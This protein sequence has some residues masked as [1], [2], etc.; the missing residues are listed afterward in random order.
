M[1]SQG[2]VRRAVAAAIGALALWAATAAGA[3]A[4]S[5]IEISM[6]SDV[7][8]FTPVEVTV[9]GVAEEAAELIVAHRSSCEWYGVPG[10]LEG[11]QL[12]PGPFT[13]SQTFTFEGLGYNTICAWLW[14]EGRWTSL[15]KTSVTAEPRKAA[16]SLAISVP[17][18][19]LGEPTTVTLSGSVDVPRIVELRP[20]DFSVLGCPDWPA[21]WPSGYA[22]P[23][24]APGGTPIGPGP[25]TVTIPW[26]PA[27]LPPAASDHDNPYGFCA[28][29]YPAG[30][31][32]EPEAKTYFRLE[33]KPPVVPPPPPR[34]V[35]LLGPPDGASGHGLNPRLSW[36]R[37]SNT[38]RYPIEQ[39]VVRITRI[40]GERRIPLVRMT[41]ERWS[42]LSKEAGRFMALP[43]PRQ[44]S[45][46]AVVDGSSLR[47][48]KPS[49]PGT[50]EW[51][52]ARS[53][54]DETPPR[55]FVV[56]A[57]Q[58]ERLSV[59]TRRVAGESSAQP[60]HVEFEVTT[61]TPFQYVRE[62]RVPGGRWQRVGGW[63]YRSRLTDW[64]GT[65]CR[66]PGGRIEWRV[67]VADSHGVER[68]QSGTVANVTRAECRR[69]KRR[70]DA[71]RRRN[72]AMVRRYKR[73]CESIGGR[74]L[75]KGRYLHC[76]SPSGRELR[77]PGF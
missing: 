33:Y 16:V 71:A 12:A 1:Q 72:E 24:T 7:V 61:G 74:F 76:R 32:T 54:H 45:E 30:R 65:S 11:E 37:A 13:R 43:R 38:R 34:Y 6:P 48:R 15:A 23:L 53:E 10:N 49:W 56:T 68:R 75:I 41:T 57:P 63:T 14:D 44:T 55:R 20:D 22:P 9:S 39:D 31:P 3:Q 29:I 2:R 5:T 51:T 17:P 46:I 67:H 42:A 21:A 19:A 64:V 69:L 4:A 77:V 27:R 60:L 52:V 47:L 59:K 70:E 8:L 26:T 58:L 35:E 40:E 28:F 66:R 73:N 18:I 25:F 62:A 50:Y 36:R